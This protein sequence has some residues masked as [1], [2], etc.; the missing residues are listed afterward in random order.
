MLLND[1]RGSF[2]MFS[3]AGRNS[4]EKFHILVRKDEILA[5]LNK[6]VKMKDLFTPDED[7]KQTEEHEDDLDIFKTDHKETPDNEHGKPGHEHLNNKSKK[8]KKP[9]QKNEIAK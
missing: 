8:K 7:F 5:G 4:A 9:K 1:N 6:R 2:G 3:R